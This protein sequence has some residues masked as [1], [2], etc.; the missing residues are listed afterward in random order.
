MGRLTDM[1][2]IKQL[3]QGAE[4]EAR[5]MGEEEPGAEHLLLSALLLPDGE[6]GRLLSAFGVDH[7]G[8]RSAILA[9]HRE[10]LVGIGM[11]QERAAWLAAPQPLDPPHG[12]G[13]FR[14]RASAQEA[15]RAAA[16]LAQRDRRS[17]LNGAH[18]VAAV[19]EMDHG[20]AAR[21]LEGLGVDRAAL[22][23]AAHAVID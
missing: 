9:Q 3:L 4:G 2:T 5:S 21:A 14:S 23:A 7:A 16:E 12:R 8:L 15:F 19:A 10:A 13:L 20:T 17:G 18:V 1:R 11:D 22:A 6:G